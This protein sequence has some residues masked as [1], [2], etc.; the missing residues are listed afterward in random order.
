MSGDK[1]K[2]NGWQQLTWGGSLAVLVA[3]RLLIIYNLLPVLE[4]VAVAVLIALV[5]RTTLQWLQRVVRVRW[6][7]VLI[8]VGIVGSLGIFI[9]LVMVPNLVAEAQTLSL[10]LPTYVNSL[11]QLS[12]QLHSS[13]RFVPD[14]SQGLQQV[15]SWLYSIIS[16]LP[17]L[18]RNILDVSLQALATLILAIYMAYDPNS[19]IEGMLRLV[20]HQ[21]HRRIKKLLQSTQVRLEGWILGTGLAMLIVGTGAAIGLW[22]LQVP[23]PLSFGVLAGLLE[24]IPYFGSIV[25]TFLPALIALTI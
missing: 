17:L 21:Q 19:L 7:A 23:L 24:V 8:L 6:I 25:G 13:V 1:N 12:S 16:F 20:P 22:F 11:I 15:R 14:L 5:L 3:A 9:G 10:A 4:L 18:L 2:G